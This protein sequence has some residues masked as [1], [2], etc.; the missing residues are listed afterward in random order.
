MGNV[1]SVISKTQIP[2]DLVDMPGIS[3]GFQPPSVYES[4]LC[5]LGPPGDGKSTFLNSDPSIFVMDFERGGRTV[6]DPRAIRFSIPHDVDPAKADEFVAG[7]IRRIVERKLK[8]ATDIKMIALDTIDEMIE[9]FLDAACKRGGVL[10]PMDLKDGFSNGYTVVRKQVFG[11]LDYIYRSGLGWA[12]AAHIATKT[13]R[14]GGEDKQLTG[15]AITDSFQKPLVRKCEHQLFL[16]RGT[17]VE[18]CPG[19]DREV[20][21][22]IVKGQP[23]SRNV[24]CRQITTKPGGLWKGGEASDVKVRVP[25]PETICLPRKGGF[26]EFIQAY[27]Q[28]VK[29]LIGATE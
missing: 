18:V 15:L 10:D 16:S 25:L 24:E 28:A 3:T 17:R 19:E 22:R 6:A 1:E 4:R 20:S 8:G 21:G 23:I 11:L 12:V 9:L 14:V 7:A 2:K 13:V 29:T 5:V 26:G 27:N